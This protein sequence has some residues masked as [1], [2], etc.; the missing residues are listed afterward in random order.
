MD[1]GTDN[2]IKAALPEEEVP[3]NVQTHWNTSK[4]LESTTENTRPPYLRKKFQLKRRKNTL[5]TPAK[6]KH[7]EHD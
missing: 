6:S 4:E 3:S 7:R 2:T 1:V 5:K